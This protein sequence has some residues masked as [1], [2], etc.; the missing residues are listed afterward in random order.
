MEALAMAAKQA[1]MPIRPAC[2]LWTS[3]TA[4]RSLGVGLE[5][6]EDSPFPAFDIDDQH[7]GICFFNQRLKALRRQPDRRAAGRSSNDEAQNDGWRLNSTV[8]PVAVTAPVLTSAMTL[9]SSCVRLITGM[10]RGSAST[11]MRC[12]AWSFAGGEA[13]YEPEAG[14]NLRILSPGRIA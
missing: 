5:P 3:T 7:V 4:W 12:A 14:T 1:A 2:G 10:R 13:G 11:T 6:F 9:L 8:P